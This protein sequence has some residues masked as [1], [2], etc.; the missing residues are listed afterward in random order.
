[1]DDRGVVQLNGNTVTSSGISN[2]LGL[3]GQ[4][5]FTKGG[6]PQ[7]YTFEHDYFDTIFA[8]ITTGF[9]AGL[10]TINLIL[11]DTSGGLGFRD[12]L[13]S[14]GYF[15]YVGRC[16]DGSGCPVS[17]VRNG[18]TYFRGNPNPPTGVE[19]VGI[20]NY[21]PGTA[22][23]VPV[24]AALPLLASGLGALGFAGWRRSKS[25]KA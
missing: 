12:G 17:E 15:W 2:L 9:K 22:S 1:M 19:F 20:V 21:T 6:A 25:S 10:N 5:V 8:P 7:A 11:N 16:F 18:V 3:N 23:T 24:P 14:G 4:M 13:L